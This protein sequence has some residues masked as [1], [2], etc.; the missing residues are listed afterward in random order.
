MR[1]KSH[2][3]S[4]VARVVLLLC[5]GVVFAASARA[6]EEAAHDEP[7]LV[8]SVPGASGAVY[9]PGRELVVIVTEAGEILE[10]APDG[11]VRRRSMLDD[12]QPLAGVAVDPR[13]GWLYAVQQGRY[14]VFELDPTIHPPVVRRTFDLDVEDVPPLRT[15][16]DA[17]LGFSGICF[18]PP[19]GVERGGRFMLAHAAAP[20]GLVEVQ[21]ALDDPVP[22][23]PAEPMP[24][25]FV[26][27][28]PVYLEDI[29]EVTF[30]LKTRS[31]MVLNATQ[32]KLVWLGLDGT[33][34]RWTRLHGH[35]L[36]GLALLPDRDLLV[37]SEGGDVGRLSPEQWGDTLPRSARAMPK[38]AEAAEPKPPLPVP[39]HRVRPERPSI[40]DDL[41][42]DLH[43]R[44][45]WRRYRPNGWILFGFGGQFLFMMRFVVQWYVSERRKRVTVPV[46]FWYISIAGSLTILI[47]A[48]HR[49]DVVFIAGQGLA[50][51]IYVRNLML[52]YRRRRQ[53]AVAVG[54]R[55]AAGIDDGTIQDGVTDQP[56]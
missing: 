41:F 17:P 11:A 12:P 21:L 39:Y 51:S 18:L 47:Y 46:V 29:S 7:E 20:A 31:L 5:A 43:R 35:A 26:N 36:D 6:A 1:N 3:R 14:R 15:K 52:I 34:L 54:Y 10:A 53:A 24:M 4:I 28:Y 45:D 56:L 48:V 30:D 22:T 49:R 32:P 42:P 44:N 19:Y 8:M 9:W 16:R 23:D 50:C 40:T 33:E 38:P 2:G 27:W 13:T 55:R 37:I 25:Q